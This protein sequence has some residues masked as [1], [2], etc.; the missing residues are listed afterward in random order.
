MTLLRLSGLFMLLAVQSAN[1]TDPTHLRCT[2]TQ[3][4]LADPG[5]FM[6][7]SVDPDH[8]V[9]RLNEQGE[10][11]NSTTIYRLTEMNDATVKGAMVDEN[12]E[13]QLEIDRISGRVLLYV[14]VT[15]FGQR[16]LKPGERRWSSMSLNCQPTKPVM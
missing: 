4:M 12:G 14:E 5:R 10:V 9:I 15:R 8:H 1:A 6:I 7:V 11:L 13:Q 2:Y 16:D 3:P